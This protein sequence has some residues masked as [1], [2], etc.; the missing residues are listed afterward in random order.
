MF[1]D[2]FAAELIVGM[3]FNVLIVVGAVI[4]FM[5]RL[6]KIEQRL[7]HIEDQISQI[8]ANK[9]S[10]GH[11][12]RFNRFE[13]R[14]DDQENSFEHHQLDIIQRLAHMEAMLNGRRRD[15][16]HDQHAGD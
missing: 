8:E 9:L 5:M 16:D 1:M 14:L 6:A 15:R 4:T 13:K 2:A 7:G 12:E 3:V 11:V 10:V